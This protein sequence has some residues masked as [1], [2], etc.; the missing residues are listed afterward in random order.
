MSRLAE[1]QAELQDVSAAVARAEHTLATH[2]NVPSVLATLQTIQKRRKNLEE[3][4]AAEANLLGLDVC[5][6]RIE[7]DD[8]QLTVHGIS[9]VLSSFQ[10][11]F[12]A[13]YDAVCRFRRS[14]PAIPI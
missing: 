6:Y 14:R 7:P 8:S 10:R 3:A 13:V 9:E 5:S 11:L 12:T 2:P 4:F 1:L